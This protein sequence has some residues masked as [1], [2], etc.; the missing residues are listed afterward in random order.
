MQYRVAMDTAAK[1]GLNP[2]EE[3]EK[4]S[5]QYAIGNRR[6]YDHFFTGTGVE[7]K[8]SSSAS[9]NTAGSSQQPSAIASY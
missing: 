3:Y 4:H 7:R 9:A 6:P 1:A 5:N 8:A 2:I